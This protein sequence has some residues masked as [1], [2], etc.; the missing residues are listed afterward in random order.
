MNYNGSVF[1]QRIIF[2]D[3]T[4]SFSFWILSFKI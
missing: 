4:V 2:I 1:A 3:I